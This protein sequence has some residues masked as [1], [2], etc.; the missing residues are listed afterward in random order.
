MTPLLPKNEILLWKMILTGEEP[1][2]SQLQPPHSSEDRKPLEEN[3][4]IEYETR[5][6]NRKRVTRL[7]LTDKAWDWASKTPPSA[8]AQSKSPQAAVVLE[9]ALTKLVSYLNQRGLSLVDFVGNRDPLPHHQPPADTS[10]WQKQPLAEKILQVS[11][12][13][14][15][16]SRTISL[17]DLR[18]RLPDIP[19]EHLD[20]ELLQL[21]RSGRI[22]IMTI[23][24]PLAITP[25]IDEAAI[26]I[27]GYKKHVLLIKN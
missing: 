25:E 19:R 11:H 13:L 17:S 24:D 27:L 23:D 26:D 12:E 21:E 10:S 14:G 6:E 8:I 3:G 7:V 15:A 5:I 16:L 4:L 9:L 18:K 22:A 20:Q 1:A 2:K